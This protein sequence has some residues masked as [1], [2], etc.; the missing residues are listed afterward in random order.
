MHIIVY[1]DVQSELTWFWFRIFKYRQF[2][3]SIYTCNLFTK[4][5]YVSAVG[6]V[7][8]IY[9]QKEITNLINY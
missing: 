6:D 9:K 4:E 1:N 5:S 8:E 3:I 2:G 7:D